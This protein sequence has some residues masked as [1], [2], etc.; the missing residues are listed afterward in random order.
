MNSQ[1]RDIRVTTF[2]DSEVNMLSF[3]LSS[4]DLQVRDWMS[5][6]PEYLRNGYLN[7]SFHASDDLVNADVV[8]SNADSSELTEASA[9]KLSLDKRVWSGA[10]LG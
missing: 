7:L 3:G 9:P 2:G 8:N 10:V 1:E 5:D 4:F 6:L